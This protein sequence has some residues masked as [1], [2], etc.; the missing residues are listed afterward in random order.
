LY[1]PESHGKVEPIKLLDHGLIIIASA[2]LIWTLSAATSQL[3]LSQFSSVL[4]IGFASLGSGIWFICRQAKEK[5][6]M[7]PLSFFQERAFTGG[8][9]ATACLYGAMYGVVFFLPQ[10]LQLNGHA[11]ALTAGLELLPWTGTLVVV[12]PFAG[13]AV[14]QFGERWLAMLG[15]VLQGIGYWLIA[16]FVHK[17]YGWLVLPLMLAGVGLSMASPALQK[18][19][20][21]AVPRVAIGKASGIYNIFRLLGGALGTTLAVI[22]F[23]QFHG[24]DFTTGFQATMLA[25]GAISLLGLVGA[26]NLTQN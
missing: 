23:Y 24:S 17:N 4:L 9:L 13:R 7:I 1:L 5:V 22:V 6:P 10:F 14:D 15:L 26:K 2:G 16:L 8:N 20:L 3:D 18:A 12:A 11:N 25:T 19:V 21:G